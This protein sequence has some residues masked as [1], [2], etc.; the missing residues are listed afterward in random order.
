[1]SQGHNLVNERETDKEKTRI[2][3][4]SKKEKRKKSGREHMD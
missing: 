4:E 1:V 3:Y 2:G